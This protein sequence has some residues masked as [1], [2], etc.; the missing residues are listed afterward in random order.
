MYIHIAH[1]VR[2]VVQCTNIQYT[3]THSEARPVIIH[4][5]SIQL[6]HIYIIYIYIYIFISYNHS[7]IIQKILPIIYIDDYR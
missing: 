2:K 5:I 1:Y 6:Q 4:I 3:G 7:S